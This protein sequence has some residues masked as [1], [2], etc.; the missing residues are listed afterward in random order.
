MADKVPVIVM[1]DPE[2]GATIQP[3]ASSIAE[4][5]NNTNADIKGTGTVTGTYQNGQWDADGTI[6]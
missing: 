4:F 2:E 1:V 6:D 3:F 5:V